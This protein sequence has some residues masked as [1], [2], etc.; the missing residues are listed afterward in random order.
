MTSFSSGGITP[1]GQSP[2]F[3]VVTPTD[4]TAWIV[5]AT[6]LGLSWVLLFG[7]G[8]LFVRCTVN[9]GFALDDASF[10]ASTVSLHNLWLQP[11]C[12]V[13]GSHTSV[14]PR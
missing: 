5:I 7:C 4:H 11:V 14:R 3:A 8:R 9:P 1:P 2:P 13:L 6:A 12:R 10:A